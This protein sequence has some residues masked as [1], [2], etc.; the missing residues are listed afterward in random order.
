MSK[1]NLKNGPPKEF[2]PYSPEDGQKL[3]DDYFKNLPVEIEGFKKELNELIPKFESF[4]LI[5]NICHHNHLRNMDKPYDDFNEGRMA[6]LPELVALWALRGDYKETCLI[7]HHEFQENIQKVNELAGNYLGRT[8][9]LSSRETMPSFLEDEKTI[10][11]IAKKL[12]RDETWV[13]NPGFPDHHYEIAGELFKP[14]EPDIKTKFGFT[15]ADSL[16]IRK[17]LVAYINEKLAGLIKSADEK[18][19]ELKIEVVKFRNTGFISDASILTRSQFHEL[20]G[21]PAKKLR[22]ILINHFRNDVLYD[23]REIYGLKISELASYLQIEDEVV[24]NFMDCF[25]CTFNTPM[26]D[27]NLVG[28]N[29]LLKTKPIIKHNDTYIIPSFAL[30]TWCVEPA[31]EEYFKTSPKLANRFKDIKHNFLLREGMKLLKRLLPTAVHFPENLYYDLDSGEKC[32]TDGLISYNNTLFIIEA[33]GHRLSTKAKSGNFQRT[34]YHLNDL[35]GEATIQGKRTADFIK[36][37]EIAEFRTKKNERYSLNRRQFDDYITIGLTLEPIGNLTPLMKVSNDLDYFSEHE[38]P[39]I[40]SIYDL[41]VFADHLEMPV[42]FLHYLKRRKRFLE[43]QNMYVFEEIDLLGYYLTSGLYI[44]NT[45]EK[46]RDQNIHMMSYDNHTDE[47]N[48][49]YMFK[50][51]HK[52]KV[53]TKLKSY[54]TEEFQAILRAIEKS[55]IPHKSDIMIIMLNVGSDSMKKLTDYIKRIKKQSINDDEI[56]DCSIGTTDANDSRGI[57]FM[58]GPVKEGLEELL[59]KYCNHK[60]VQQKAKQWIGI[61]DISKNINEYDFRCSFYYQEGI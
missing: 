9:A 40:V 20:K 61:G 53:V 16:K 6:V 58:V 46:A 38:F 39:W 33:K 4:Q 1:P 26:S 18:A 34:L 5:A 47:F 23:L 8:D 57:T 30:F 32:E 27:E 36:S 2:M 15:I 29:V 59:N 52:E 41:I 21:Y 44:E 14:F 31:I 28:S 19:D 37:R 11:K 51:G 42:Q 56:H 25:S 35:I 45:L 3:I 54:L 13:R 12:S 60:I 17:N 22:I 24:R 48:D 43:I 49:Y 10:Q 50:Y 55:S 7:P